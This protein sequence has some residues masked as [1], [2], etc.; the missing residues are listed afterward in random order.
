MYDFLVVGG[1][2]AGLVAAKLARELGK[3]VLLVEK[4]HL[5]G[6]CT[7]TGCVPSKAIIKS[8]Y[9][10]LMNK[11]LARFGLGTVP[12]K[13]TLDTSGVMKHVRT[14]VQEIYATHTPEILRESG[15]HVEFGQPRFIDNHHISLNGKTISFAKALI[16]TGTHACI[17]PIEGLE[18]VPYLTNKTFFELDTLPE[19]M[20]IVGGGPIGC[21]MAS[22]LNRLGVKITLIESHERL[23]VHEDPE[24]V[25]HIIAI[26]RSEGVIVHTGW[27]ANKVSRIQ[28]T[29]TFDCT[30][31]QGKPHTIA[32]HA[33]LIAVGR[34]PNVEGLDLEKAGVQYTKKSI[35]VD[36]TLRTTAVNIWA[37]GDVVG[38]YLFSH[39]AFYQARCATQN[40]FNLFSSKP[41]SY[42]EVMWVTF[43]D[44]ELA[45]C[46]LTEPEARQIYGDTIQVYRHN[47][48]FDRSVIDRETHGLCKIICDS[49]GYILGTQIVGTRA[50]EII[51]E[52]Q[53][54][55]VFGKKLADIYG[56]M[57]AYPTYSEVIW[58]TARAAYRQQK[59]QSVW[60]RLKNWFAR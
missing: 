21:E 41:I 22:S 8:G 50:G 4:H 9:A 43:T 27:H 30:D 53:T 28:N 3:T 56:I 37:A 13:V 25:D 15:V 52:M 20:V 44:P 49:H 35:V 1:G 11:N 42:D 51:Q 59:S 45:N 32:G 29:I 12:E 14:V 17:P 19:S 58:L 7:W 55:K 57:H 60:S 16:A 24:L 6:E 34:R 36:R 2:G 10:A 46:G 31:D 26:L 48:T 47:Y 38:P 23:L 40:A 18:Q 39:I 54:A 5:G 33:V